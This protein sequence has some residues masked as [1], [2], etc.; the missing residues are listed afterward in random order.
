MPACQPAAEPAGSPARI[1]PAGLGDVRDGPAGFGVKGGRFGLDDRPGRRFGRGG[2]GQAVDG[3]GHP[4]LDRGLEP[5]FFAGAVPVPGGAPDAVQVPAQVAEYL[6][7]EPVT[8]AGGPGGVVL[9]AVAF[10]AQRVHAGVAG[11]VDADVDA[12]PGGADPGGEPVPPGADDADDGF[13]EWGFGASGGAG[14]E[15]G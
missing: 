15:R 5:A 4:A 3:R 13:L 2:A 12:V 11:V 1:T 14:R 7:A 9:V 10:D 6:L 8:V